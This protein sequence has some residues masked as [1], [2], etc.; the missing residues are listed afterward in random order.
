MEQENRHRAGGRAAAVESWEQ[1]GRA[2]EQEEPSYLCE[3]LIT[4]IGNKRALLPQLE[5]EIR[6]VCR[7]AGREKLTCLDLFS[8]SGAVS[9][10]LKRYASSLYVNDWETYARVL[11]QC[12]LANRST[13]PLPELTR[14]L[15][16]IRESVREG[17]REGFIARL[18]APED[19]ACIRPGERVFF[20][21]RNALYIDTVRALIDEF[22]AELRPFFLAPLLYEASVHANTSG[23]FK[24][25]Y[26]N[27]KGIGQYGGEGR[28][29]LSRIRG[30]M[31]LKLPVFSRFE[32]ENHL[33]QK[34]AME[35]IQE[36]PELD[37]AYLDP[38]YN[39]H[40]YGSN[41]FMLNLI[42]E[43]QP[44][45]NCSAVS[46]I[47]Q[48]W[49][50]SPYNKAGRAREELFRL[51]ALC[52]ARWILLSYNSEGF[53]SREELLAF[54]Q[55]L[56][57]ARCRDIPY[58]TFRGCRNLSRRATRVTEYLFLLERA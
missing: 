42:A 51:I 55:T 17:W 28:H 7:R 19:E 33:M 32:T 58:Q 11:N 13:V 40:P 45:E 53:V 18:Y 38:P 30:D 26:K 2:E 48:G 52:P 1:A 54:L 57:R 56:G 9:R 20:T 35:A 16:D 36:L 3:Q 29:A 21:R 25:F 23:V 4:Y 50:R 49:K 44:P 12:Y 14:G 8:G 43:N 37:F 22:P 24:G 31:E 34:E 39:Q 5:E 10:L 41:Y 15:K 27:R 47:P 6:R 46:G